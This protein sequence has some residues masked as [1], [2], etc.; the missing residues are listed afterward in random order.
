MDLL[1]FLLFKVPLRKMKGKIKQ[2]Q[3]LTFQGS[4]TSLGILQK[5]GFLLSRY[6]L[7]S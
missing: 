4:G 6:N 2:A 3:N 7:T 5:W 1:V